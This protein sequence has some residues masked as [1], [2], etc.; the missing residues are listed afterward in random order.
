LPSQYTEERIKELQKDNFTFSSQYQQEPI[1]EGGNL[2]KTEWF[3]RYNDLP[4]SFE[5]MYIV[6][7]TAFSEKKSADNT[8]FLL[9][10]EYQNKL[11]LV[12]CYCKKVLFPDMKRDLKN[13]YTSRNEEYKQGYI[14]TIYI[15]NKGSG[16]SLIQELRNEGLP[17]SELT[18]TVQVKNPY[19]RA[20][21][22]VADKY[23]RFLEVSSDLESGYVA[24]P[25]VSNWVIDFIKECEAFDGGITNLHDDRVDCLIYA[26]KVRR[27]SKQSNWKEL[28]NVFRN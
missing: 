12:D 8:V 4:Q 23:T 19:I 26:L 6:C 21:E 2:I 13:F 28:K 20:E 18:P 11:Y 5:S 17:I 27:Q 7:D 10:G 15:E 3:S 25:T 22:K 24:L 1:L 9:C 16:I 14:R